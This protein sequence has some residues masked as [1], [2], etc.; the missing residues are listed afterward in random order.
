MWTYICIPLHIWFCP[1]VPQHPNLLSPA[2]D[3]G[4]GFLSLL[5]I[6]IFIW[7]S[8]HLRL[9]NRK[10]FMVFS[11]SPFFS[12]Y[13]GST[14]S[15]YSPSCSCFGI[16]FYPK[17]SIPKTT[18]RS[19]MPDSLGIFCGTA[20]AFVSSCKHQLMD[21]VDQ[22]ILTI[23]GQSPPRKWEVKNSKWWLWVSR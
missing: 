18:V 23:G 19:S 5:E 9:P 4:C 17:Q 20:M 13:A 3:W 22:L 16:R 2:V 6:F 21:Q 11:F 14:A 1:S 15:N 7:F 12:A 8:N 10:L